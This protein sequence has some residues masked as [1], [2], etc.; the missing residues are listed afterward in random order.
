MFF[1]DT[2][3]NGAT[4]VAVVGKT[5]VDNLFPDMDPQS[6]IGQSIRIFSQGG[7]GGGPER[8]RPWR[9]QRRIVA[10]DGA[11]AGPG[12]VCSRWRRALITRD[13]GS[14]AAHRRSASARTS[15]QV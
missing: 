7:G 11:T 10:S 2:A 9:N 12:R 6:V 13:G 8:Q 5:I 3:V 14:P 15:G 4:K 1:E